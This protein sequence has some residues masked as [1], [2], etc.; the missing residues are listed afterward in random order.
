LTSLSGGIAS[1]TRN[2]LSERIRTQPYM[3]IGGV[4]REVSQISLPKA[5][6]V[7]EVPDDLELSNEVF[8]YRSHYLFDPSTNVIQVTRTLDAH[9]GKQVCTPDDFKAALPVLKQIERDTQEQIIVKAE[10]H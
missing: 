3:C 4:Y 2:W 9:F 5:M 8:N 6:R 7:T 10:R 1:L